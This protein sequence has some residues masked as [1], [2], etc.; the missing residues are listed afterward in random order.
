MIVNRTHHPNLQNH[1][2]FHLHQS[3]HSNKYVWTIFLSIFTHISSL[4]IDTVVGPVYSI[5]N[6]TK[7]QHLNS[8]KYYAMYLPLRY[9]G[10]D[11][12]RWRPSIQGSIQYVLHHMG[13]PSS[14]ILSQLRPIEWSCGSG[15]EEYETHATQQCI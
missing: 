2:F 14:S 10:R 11:Q 13:H 9:P 15:C 5:S 1:S 12:F 4:S 7:Q 8:L 3:S 6:H